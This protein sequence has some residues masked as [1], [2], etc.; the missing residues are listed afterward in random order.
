MPLDIASA[1]NDPDFRDLRVELRVS[2]TILIRPKNEVAY[3]DFPTPK[4]FYN[5]NKSEKKRKETL[6]PLSE[7]LGPI[8]SRNGGTY[9]T[10]RHVTV[11]TKTTVAS[12]FE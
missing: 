6:K 5:L 10:L 7:D 1:I 2:D 12:K 8:L 3:V 9:R 4:L 11:S